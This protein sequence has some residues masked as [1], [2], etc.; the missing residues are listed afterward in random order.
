[1]SAQGS[2]SVRWGTPGFWILSAGLVLRLSRRYPASGP[3][4]MAREFRQKV[5][6][7]PPVPKPINR[8]IIVWG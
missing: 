3:Q 6:C 2:S 4:T 8:Q 7:I 5:R 1:M